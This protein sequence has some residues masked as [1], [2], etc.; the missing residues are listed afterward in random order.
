MVTGSGERLQV[1]HPGR[2]N[3][4]SGPDFLGAIIATDV[5]GLLVGDV[6]IHRRGRHRWRCKMAGWCPL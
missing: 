4:D 5:S 2:Q 1:I 6:E 3:R